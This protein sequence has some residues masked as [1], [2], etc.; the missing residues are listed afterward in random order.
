M[1]KICTTIKYLLTPSMLIS[2]TATGPYALA[3]SALTASARQKIILDTD[4]GDDIDDAFALALAVSSPKV[5]VVGVTTAL[6]RHRFARP[7]CRA[8]S[9]SN[10]SQRHSRFRRPENLGAQPTHAGAMGLRFP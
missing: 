9:R 7:A 6:G 10:G 2:L 3:Q 4:I 8:P 5:Q 1:G